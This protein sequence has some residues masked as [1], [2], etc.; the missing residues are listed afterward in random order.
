MVMLEGA[1]YKDYVASLKAKE[2]DKSQFL[3]FL[4]SVLQNKAI[5][6]KKDKLDDKEV[7]IVLQKEKKKLGETKEAVG[8][9]PEGLKEVNREIEIIENYL[10]EQMPK[11]QIENIVDQVI[12]DT[13]AGSVKDMGKVIKPVLEETAGRA[14]SKLVSQIVKEKLSA[15]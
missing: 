3:S 13:A 14:D 6:L 4:R 2:K 10:P 9:N 1:I 12:A 7:L 5:E 15:P 8:D 11:S